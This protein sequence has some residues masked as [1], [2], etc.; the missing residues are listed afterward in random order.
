LVDATCPLVKAV[1]KKATQLELEGFDIILIGHRRTHRE[2]EGVVG[3]P[4]KA[5]DGG[6]IRPRMS[7]LAPSKGIAPASLRRP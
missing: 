5:S 4:F 2:I 3:R 7:P 1:H 6:R